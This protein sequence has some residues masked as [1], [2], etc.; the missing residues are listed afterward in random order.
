[1]YTVGRRVVHKTK[2][3]DW[4]LIGSCFVIGQKSLLM[5]DM[6]WFLPSEEQF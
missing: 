6:E 1:M 5:F 3:D 4:S 2:T